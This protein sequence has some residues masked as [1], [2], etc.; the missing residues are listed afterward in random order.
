MQTYHDLGTV[1]TDPTEASECVSAGIR[2]IVAGYAEAYGVPPSH[3]WEIITLA[4][5]RLRAAE[6]S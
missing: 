6:T 1:I 4:H 2:R 5:L 3:L